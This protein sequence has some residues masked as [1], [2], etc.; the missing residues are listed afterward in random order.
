MD[1][2]LG[3][4]SDLMRNVAKV[5][6]RIVHVDA[7][8]EGV[9]FVLGQTYRLCPG[10]HVYWPICMKPQIHPVKRDTLH[11]EP[12]TLPYSKDCPLGLTINVTVVYTITDIVKALVDT[13][14]FIATIRDRAQAGVI[15]AIL[16][17]TIDELT[18]NHLKI[19]HAIT[20]KIRKDLEV[21]G[22][23]VETAFMSDFH[24]TY[25]HR[26]LGNSPSQVFHQYTTTQ[27]EEA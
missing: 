1:L 5:L 9:M 22:V 19:N 8:Q 13:Y 16:G 3:W 21:F 20:K 24:L 10:V 2:G 4:L 17:K 23:H 15:S 27:S 18:T 6:P 26:I 7:T 11:L 14:D 12:Q 25:M